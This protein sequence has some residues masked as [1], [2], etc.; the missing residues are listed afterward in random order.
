MELLTSRQDRKSALGLKICEETFSFVL[1]VPVVTS[2]FYC[3]DQFIKFV[4]LVI[5]E[6]LEVCLRSE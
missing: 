5:H 6:S 1:M 4:E 3:T 2:F